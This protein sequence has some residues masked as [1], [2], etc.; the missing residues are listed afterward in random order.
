MEPTTLV[1]LP[2]LDGTG[3][4]LEPLL[5][6]LPASIRP[7]VVR[8][9]TT[10]S[11]SYEELLPLAREAARG[12]E[13]FFVLGWSFGGPLALRLAAESGG[14][15]E[16]VILCAT[17]VRAPRPWLPRLRVAARAPVIA[18]I[19]ALWRSR[20][21]LSGYPSD[22]YREAKSRT[23]RE[24]GA[25]AL[26][27]RTRALMVEDARDVLR[28][29]AAPLLYLAA[30]R[31]IVVPPTNLDEIRSIRPDT[32]V[33]TLE[34]PHLALFTDAAR[35]AAQIEQFIRRRATVRA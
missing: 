30:S 13:R 12:S 29:C 1:L 15:V 23:W 14:R 16:G 9:P 34:G 26:A 21:L 2:G 22:E 20:F 32:E 7:V 8:Y 27:A 11:N 10:G 4:F 5:G 6:A 3:I 28:A 35:A 31:D 33:A 19:R 25:T 17:F 24:V 18:A